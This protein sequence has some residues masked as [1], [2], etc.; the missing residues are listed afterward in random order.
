M[1]L[2]KIILIG[3]ALSLPSALG[4]SG[5]AKTTDIRNVLLI[6]LDTTR[7][8][9]LGCYGYTKAL[10]PNLDRLAGQGIQFLNAYTH[11]PLTLPAHCSI[12]TGTLPLY[13]Q[14]HNNGFYALD[15]QI[16]T[17]AEVFQRAGYKTG[18][19]VASFTVDSR[20]GLDR[21]FQAYDDNFGS[22]EILKNFRS[23]RRAGEVVEAFIPWLNATLG[24]E[25]FAWI[26]FYD[27]HLPYDPPSPFKE[28]F[29]ERKY[30][31]EI[32]YM[33]SA[34]G[35]VVESLRKAGI[36][37]K[38]LIVVAGDHGE[39]LGEHKEIE[40][41]LFLYEASMR[42]PLLFVCK[43][44]LPAGKAVPAKVGL[45]DIMPT[46]LELAGLPVPKTVQ[47]TSLLPW[48]SGRKN[49][50]RTTYMETYYP[51][52][53]FGWSEFKGVVDG[54]W[55]FIQAPRPELYDLKKDPNEEDNL[56]EK[57][58]AVSRE[59]VTKLQEIIKLRS[60]PAPASPRRTS[61]EDEEKLRSLGYLGGDRL[62]G[63]NKQAW[64]DPK[65]KIDDY[66]LY[67]RGDLM[68]GEGRFDQALGCYRE[69]LR[70]NP[71][72]PSYYVTVGFLLMKM[73]RTTEA[74]ELL[75][76]ARGKFPTS[77]LVLSRLVSFYLRAE[78]WEDAI[79]SGRALLDLQ[80][81][82]FDAL[83]LSGS[84]YAKLGKWGEA[85]DHYGRALKTEPENKTLR[86]RYSYALAAVGRYDE[87]LDSYG[88]LRAEYPGDYSLDLDVGRI[89]ANMGRLAKAREVYES[90]AQR[91]PCADTFHDLAMFLGRIGE[92]RDAVRWLKAYLAVTK[93]GDT[94]RK[95]QAQTSLAAWEKNIKAPV[96]PEK[97]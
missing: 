11:V 72:V 34:I 48:I 35:V 88:R 47:G 28:S 92:F 59:M 50:D 37:D 18:A 5:A 6:T 10:T 68:E 64:P 87:A 54:T 21:G 84:A 83:F 57:A 15:G 33:D 17:L 3:A 60:R 9:R 42:V 86:Q 29:A 19:F 2:V 45:A 53:N 26:H 22:E 61:A 93:E 49:D 41:G 14:V 25:I 66:L 52:E 30:D 73:G 16:P 58:P 13:H 12:L 74:V 82:D 90:A 67:Y 94:P 95:T 71:E 75:E 24:R 63:P 81:D 32:A 40:H 38:T 80:P 97:K 56:Y 7:A 69:V 89:Y 43:N 8:D 78:R 36:L 44:K 23:E 91:F 79:A 1:H 46:I 55:K 65:D 51:R 70:R 77:V 96:L 31:G 62:G 4:A 20:F 39:A 76:D 27:P 85:L